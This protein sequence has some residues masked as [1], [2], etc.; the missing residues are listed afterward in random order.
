MPFFN[1]R[2]GGT[3]VQFYLGQ[4]LNDYGENVRIYS[5]SGKKIKNSIY[6]KYYNNDFPI[7]DNCLVIYCEGTLGNPLNAKY[8]VR[9]MLSKLGQNVPFS[10]L[11]TWGKNELVYYFNSEDKIENNSEKKGTIYKLLTCIYVNPYIQ[12][13]NFEERSGICYTIRKGPKIHK[14]G[15]RIVHP[16]D[17]F[18]ITLKHKQMDY[19]VIF[20]KHKWFISYDSLTFL[21]VIAL[22]CGCI[23]VIYKVEG[24]SKL[25]WI[26]TTVAV[27]Y[28]KDKGLD[29]L[30]GIAY[31]REDMKYAED[32]IHLAK[33]Q[34]IDIINYCK[35]K[36]ILSFI[37]DI[38]N[39]ENME[40]TIQNN[41][42]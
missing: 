20:N 42:Y 6:S 34:W 25:E 12:K 41:F 13:T 24:L 18:E 27:E 33:D 26:Y 21:I 4:I 31:G 19:V 22:I 5:P 39:F 32:T 11:N 3:V 17:S 23:P 1:F 40:N 16:K 38:Q 8:C 37:N 10:N 28:L 36:T 15:F 30:Y 14:N 9:W 35:E 7:D 29:N 2:D